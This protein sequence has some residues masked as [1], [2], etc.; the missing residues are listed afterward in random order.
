VLAEP[1]LI[2]MSGQEASFLAGGEFPIPVPQDGGDGSSTITIDYKQFGVKLDFVPTVL[3]DGKIRLKV[4]PEVS[5]LDFSRSVSFGGF[6]IPGLTKRTVSTTIELS[7][8]QTFA[9][10]GLLNNRVVASKD[11]TPL[12]GDLPVLGALFRSVRYER[13]ETELVVLVTPRLVAPLNPDEVGQLPG[14]KWTDPTELQLFLDRNIGMSADRAA[15]RQSVPGNEPAA[16]GAAG[17]EPAPEPAAPARFRGQYGFV[18]AT[19]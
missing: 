13:S 5:D 7:E 9:V 18:P 4:E 10:A 8:G 16:G 11:V 3:G 1:N 15:T 17:G 6:V 12:L 14:E 19:N 2:A